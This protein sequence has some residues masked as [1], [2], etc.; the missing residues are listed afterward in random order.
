M[1]LANWTS[2]ATL[3]HHAPTVGKD[4]VTCSL[5]RTA[6]SATASATACSATPITPN[7][8]PSAK[9]GTTST[10]PL[11]A[12]PAPIIVFS[13]SVPIFA[14]RVLSGTLFPR[15]SLKASAF[16]ASRHARLVLES[17]LTAPLA[18]MA[19]PKGAGNAKIILMSSSLSL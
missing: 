18:S 6:S 11:F 8:A 1:G 13:A 2:R 17:P 12:Q 4:W 10:A 16:S 15:G 3:T 9:M 7:N 5:D 19:L 14:V